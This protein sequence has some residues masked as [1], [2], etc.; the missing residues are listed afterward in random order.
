MSSQ[1]SALVARTGPQRAKRART[2]TGACAAKP[3][4]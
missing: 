2:R 4:L 3:R 1:V